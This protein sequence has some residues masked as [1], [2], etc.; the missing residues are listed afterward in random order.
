MAKRRDY[1]LC[2]RCRCDWI[3]TMLTAEQKVLCLSCWNADEQ[4]RAELE[5]IPQP[6]SQESK[7]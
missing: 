2:E 3:P 4:L 7:R 6:E 1:N 5:N